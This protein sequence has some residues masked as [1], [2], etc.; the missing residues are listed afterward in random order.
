MK[1]LLTITCCAA[2]VLLATLMGGCT[3]RRTDSD[4]VANGDTVDVVVDGLGNTQS[5]Q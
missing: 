5:E 4:P 3:E 2:A 1:K